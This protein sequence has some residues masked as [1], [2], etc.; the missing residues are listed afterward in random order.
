MSLTQQL[1]RIADVLG[2][3]IELNTKKHTIK[4]GCRVQVAN[5]GLEFD[6]RAEAYVETKTK[7][8]LFV[9]CHVEG[10]VLWLVFE[11]SP[12]GTAVDTLYM[13]KYDTLDEVFGLNGGR[14]EYRNMP[15]GEGN[16]GR[17][18][19]QHAIKTFDH[20]AHKNWEEVA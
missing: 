2:M 4:G 15:C 17:L 10:S 18:L 19:L 6:L 14:P 7:G 3:D 12:S 5:V 8:E 11:P 9:L 16:V 1:Y 20:E 13:V